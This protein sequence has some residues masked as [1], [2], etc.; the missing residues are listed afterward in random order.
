MMLNVHTGIYMH[1]I[2]LIFLLFFF[3]LLCFVLNQYCGILALTKHS[4][5]NWIPKSI[6]SAPADSATVFQI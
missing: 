3:F 4:K 2:A 5:I 6:P 1:I